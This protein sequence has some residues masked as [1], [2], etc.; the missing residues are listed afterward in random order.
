MRVTLT[1]GLSSHPPLR[2]PPTHW[3]TEHPTSPER[4]KNKRTKVG[5]PEFKPHSECKAPLPHRYTTAAASLRQLS[6]DL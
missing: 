4:F 5:D 6:G 3:A 2:Y 1:L